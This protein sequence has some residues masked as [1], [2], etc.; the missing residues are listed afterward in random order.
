MWNKD[1]N[2]RHFLHCFLFL[3]FS[4]LVKHLPQNMTSFFF[5]KN[6]YF[7]LSKNAPTVIIFFYGEEK[8]LTPGLDI[9]INYL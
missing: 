2:K 3:I 7:F 1:Y 4:S 8:Q 5:L 9:F 6:Y